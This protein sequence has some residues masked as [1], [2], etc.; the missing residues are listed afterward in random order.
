MSSETGI[1]TNPSLLPEPLETSVSLRGELTNTEGAM[2]SYQVAIVSPM[3]K[4]TTDSTYL[5]KQSGSNTQNLTSELSSDAETQTFETKR[6]NVRDMFGNIYQY[7]CYL[8]IFNRTLTWDK[9]DCKMTLP[10]SAVANHKMEAYAST[11]DDIPSIYE[12][13]ALPPETRL[14]SPVIEY[15]LPGGKMLND[16]AL[17]EMPFIGNP[18]KIEVWKCPSDEGMFQTLE[19][20]SVPLLKKRDMNS[21]LFCHIENG[22]VRVYTKSF[23]IFFCTCQEQPTNL[24]LR[25]FLFGS[26]KKILDRKEV[27]LS[28]YIADELH[29]FVDYNQVM[30]DPFVED[31]YL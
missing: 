1:S 29:T 2:Q 4:V 19:C 7:S 3:T 21:E 31:K 25:A 6:I 22:K 11:F 8:D 24:C 12:K 5:E 9:S 18:E 16:F 23:S 13:F 20:R 15:R 14:V 28:L 26:Y 30:S 27:R 10:E 17:V